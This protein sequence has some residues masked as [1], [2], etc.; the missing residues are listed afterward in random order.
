M[1]IGLN[2][3]KI[4]QTLSPIKQMMNRLQTAGNPQMMLN[5]MM[6]QN[7]QMK[8]VMEY[9]NQNGGNAEQAFYK[10]AQEMGIN[11]EDVLSQLR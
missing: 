6:S 9:I 5:Q 11:P 4:A 2:Q 7:P 1:L 10:K 3:S 8:Q